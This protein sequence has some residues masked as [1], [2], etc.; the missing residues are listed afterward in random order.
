[1]TRGRVNP[2]RSLIRNLK[3]NNMFC[4][5]WTSTKAILT[6]RNAIA[7]VWKY[8]V[9]NAGVSRGRFLEGVLRGRF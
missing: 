7:T 5:V 3:N 8:Y 9:T 4:T 6:V 1:M 2:G